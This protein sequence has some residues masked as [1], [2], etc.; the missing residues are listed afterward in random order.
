VASLERSLEGFLR[1]VVYELGAAAIQTVSY[2][3][4]LEYDPAIGV[5]VFAAPVSLP[6]L[7]MR[8]RAGYDLESFSS[9]K[10]EVGDHL[11]FTSDATTKSSDYLTA[12][13]IRYNVKSVVDGPFGVASIK[14]IHGRRV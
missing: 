8:Y 1:A 9:E 5:D 3:R 6:M 4:S 13:G 14:S 12:D 11:F 7:S 10:F 2:F